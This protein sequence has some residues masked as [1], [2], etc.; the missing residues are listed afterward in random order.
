MKRIQAI[1]ILR[2]ATVALMVLVNNPGSWASAWAPLK[3]ADWNGL[4]LA[5]LVFPLFLF[6]M[7][8]SMYFSMHKGGF[9]LSWKLLKRTLMLIAI[10]LALNWIGEIIWA[11]SFSLSTLRLTGVLQ[12]FGL[13]FGISALL[14]C[15]LP[16]KSLPWVA[17]GILAAYSAILLAGN[18]YSYSA[19]NIIA[20]FDGAL[21]PAAHLYLD[22]G[23]DPEGILGTL[24]CIAHTLIGFLIGKLIYER[25]EKG[26][27]IT[28][29]VLLAVGLL[30]SIWMPLNKKIWSPSFVLV[31][32]GL[33]TLLLCAIYYLV[34]EKN[35]WTRSGFFRAFGTNAIY[36]YVMGH[37]VAWIMDGSG[38]HH[39]YATSCASTSPWLSFAYAVACVLLVWLSVLP[40]QRR[41]IFLKL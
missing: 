13:C 35:I 2:G 9:K 29:A 11:H 26:T 17:G 31:L 22:N 10:G 19:D 3:H 34:D 23:I 38:F 36:C 39:W 28:G 1:D 41:G 24:P 25:K 8:V 6:V 4:T 37:V 7:G 16:H 40:L 12:R 20:K 27:A 15:L 33:G 5:D 18:G 30:I 32:C 21:I 14:V